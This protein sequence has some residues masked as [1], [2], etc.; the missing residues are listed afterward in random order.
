MRLK[1]GF[2]KVRKFL[3]GIFVFAIIFGGGYYLGVKGYK[4]EV[5]KALNV[6]VSREI[7]PD[8]NVDFTLF[9]Q[10]WDTLSAKYFDKGKIV[11][12]KMVYGAITGMV[13]ALGDPY[14]MFLPPTQNKVVDEDLS[15]SFS[16]V[17]I[18]IGYRAARLAVVAPLAD[19]PAQKA[20]VKAGDFIIHI[21]DERKNIDLGTD[22]IT[23]PDAVAAIR[24]PSGTVVTLTLARQGTN[25]PIIVDLTRAT[26]SVPSVS[27]SYVGDEKDIADIRI[28][29]FGAE[30]AG[31][32]D[33]AVNEVMGKNEI[34]GIIIDLRNNPG[35]YLQAAVD[36]AGDFVSM[37][38]TVVIQENGDGTRN[39]LKSDRLGKLA[40][41]K[42]VVL[43]NG[44]SASA[45]EIL[46]GALRD[47]KHFKLIG[48]KSFG[49][50]TIQEPVEIRGGS[51]LHVTTA[52][53]LTPNGTWV[54][55]KGLEPDIP[56]ALKDT[57]KSDVQL[58]T[59]IKQF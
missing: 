11:P 55:E 21:K 15:G 33:K 16:G 2:S 58:D 48:D 18:E 27:L 22:G 1:L 10:V 59:A 41:Y 54:H 42:V 14:T 37:G 6:T 47:Q 50:G 8:K 13:S 34:K 57:D 7:P 52:K 24:G 20:G 26:L 28:S 9:W 4:A 35:G 40:K 25:G 51:G 31:E 29:K 3:L 17:G 44:G 43:I 45:S 39:E 38:T 30:T 49:K 56:I 19:S 5:T 32:W 36:V 12:E 23:L 46:A 53:W